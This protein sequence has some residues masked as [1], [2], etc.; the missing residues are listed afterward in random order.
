MRIEASETFRVPAEKLWPLL[1][2][3]DSLNRELG[4]PSVEYAFTPLEQGGSAVRARARVG[5][6]R[7]EWDEFPFE[8]MWPRSYSI[9]RVFHRGPMRE[10]R[11]AF[12][13]EPS[14]QGCRVDVT[15]DLEPAGVVG[16][17][18]AKPFGRKNLDKTIE[19]ARNFE[20]FLLGEIPSP[21]PNR[22]GRGAVDR[23]ELDG[24]LRQLRDTT[25]DRSLVDRLGRLI[26][27]EVDEHLCDLRPYE[28]ADA[29]KV[30]RFEVLRLCLYATRAGILDLRWHVICPS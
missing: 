14:G 29:W 4:L 8:W 6:I 7:M 23:L 27:E 11:A 13:F 10:F 18:I 17:L 16:K 21:W 26:T 28:V 30:D 22:Y 15:V 24:R 3:T 1:A 9:H 25:T 20:R 12:R 19:A 2:N 5:P